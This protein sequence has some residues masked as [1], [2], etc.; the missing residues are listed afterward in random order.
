MIFK[1]IQ[2]QQ[3]YEKNGYIII[4][5]LS[6]NETDFLFTEFKKLTPWFK[7][8]FMSICPKMVINRKL[9]HY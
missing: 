3:Q 4:D 7:D 6:S 2:H 9:M 8:G 5:F 1:K